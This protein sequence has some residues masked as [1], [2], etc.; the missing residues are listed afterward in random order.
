MKPKKRNLVE[1]KRQR[2]YHAQGISK[3]KY[4]GMGLVDRYRGGK[5]VLLRAI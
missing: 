2:Y 3:E 5:V 4:S 1:K